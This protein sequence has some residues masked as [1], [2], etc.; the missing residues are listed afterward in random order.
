MPHIN[1]LPWREDL[2]KRRNKEFGVLAL[3]TV[4]FMGGVV[5]GV[6]WHFKQRIEFQ[7]QRNV[8]LETQIAAL[9]KKIKEIQDLDREK[10][11]L[12]A[13]M[14]IIQQLQSSRPES[15]H[16][17]DSIVKTLPEGVF[18]TAI[19]QTGRAINM[20]GIA[21]SNARVSSL[22]RQLDSSEWFENPNLIEIKAINQP[23]AAGSATTA[24]KLSNFNLN[25]TQSQKKKP[26]DEAGDKKS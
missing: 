19:K 14:R 11:R 8:F 9:D 10:E 25:V 22:M 7:T 18:Y 4:L 23:T 17:I 21:Q 20:I 12:L 26:E 1:L 5:A 15:V 13:R 2:R 6:D 24:I 3:V 16:V